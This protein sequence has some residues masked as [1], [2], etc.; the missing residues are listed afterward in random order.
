MLPISSGVVAILLLQAYD[1]IE[2]L[3]ALHHLRRHVAADG[4]LDERVDVGDIEAVARDLA[5][6]RSSMVRLGCPS[7]CTKVTSRMPRTPFQH[8]LDRLALLLQRVQVGAEHLHVKE[9]FRPVSA[10]STASSAGCV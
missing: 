10:S 4:G 1:E 7:S 5:H 8:L 9:L 2:L 3:L 6:D